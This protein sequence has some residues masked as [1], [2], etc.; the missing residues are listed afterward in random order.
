M[1]TPSA[2]IGTWFRGLISVAVIFGAVWLFA[3]W[4]RELPGPVEAVRPVPREQLREQLAETDLPRPTVLMRISAW[5]PGLD[6]P[7]ALLS[8]AVFLTLLAL[9]AG[10]LSYPLIRRPGKD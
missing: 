2:V 6:K 10:R 1:F 5:R 4:Y 9:G 7:T 3:L 8:S